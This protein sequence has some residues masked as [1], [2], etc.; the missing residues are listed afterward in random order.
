MHD[1]GD[2]FQCRG[3]ARPG[4]QQLE[5]WI[6]VHSAIAH[7][8]NHRERCPE[9]LTRLIIGHLVAHRGIDDHLG[10]LG[11]HEFE[12]D[13]GPPLLRLRRDVGGPSQPQK[14]VQIASHTNGNEWAATDQHQHTTQ[15]SGR[16]ERLDTLQITLHIPHETL[17]R[18]GNTNDT[19][20]LA[21][22]REDRFDSFGS[23]DQHTQT[24]PAQI[25]HRCPIPRARNGDDEIGFRGE[26]T[27]HVG[28][29]ESPD[30]RTPRH[31]GRVVAMG[32]NSDDAIAHTEGEED[33]GH[34]RRQRDDPGHLGHGRPRHRQKNT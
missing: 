25:L 16:D 11:E 19:R 7:R 1:S 28:R 15:R 26:D 20:H 23:D 32:G 3:D 5:S 24:E 33:L 30:P 31:L 8:R 2:H 18:T 14:L 13:M 34:G 27:L 17:S 4:A 29:Q 9:G 21:D 10:S 22:R 12:T 6:A